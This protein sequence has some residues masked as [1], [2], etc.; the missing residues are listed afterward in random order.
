MKNRTS[1]VLMEQLIMVLIFSLCAALSLK[2]FSYSDRI[3]LESKAVSEAS[4]AV[5]TA[6]ETIKRNN[7]TKD[8]VIYYDANWNETDEADYVYSV[9]ID[10]IESGIDNLGKANIKASDK[11]AVLFEIPVSW[12]EVE[13]NE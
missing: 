1:L 3:S 7:G 2:A 5:Q 12:Q 4:L 10:V 6:A 8:R 11:N 9:E 13:Q